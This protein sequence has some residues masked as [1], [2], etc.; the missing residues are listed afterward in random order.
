MKEIK[1]SVESNISLLIEVVQKINS[2]T[3]LCK[4]YDLPDNGKQRKYFRY[5]VGKNNISTKH[6]DSHKKNS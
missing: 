5:I 6:W 3:D 4:Y 1:S 2:Y